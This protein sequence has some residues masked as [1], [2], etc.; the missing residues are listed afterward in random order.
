M[1]QLTEQANKKN[2]RDE[3]AQAI[4]SKDTQDLA[5]PKGAE[6]AKKGGVRSFFGRSGRKSPPSNV[7]EDEANTDDDEVIEV[8]DE[9]PD[10]EGSQPGVLEAVVDNVSVT[11]VVVVHDA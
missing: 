4:P 11:V 10:E 2:D 6:S 7:P 8:G 9:I 5:R 3:V 1:Q